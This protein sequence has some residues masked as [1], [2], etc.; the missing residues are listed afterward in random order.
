MK[1]FTVPIA[2]EQPA[3]KKS[4]AARHIAVCGIQVL[5][6]CVEEAA[7]VAQPRVVQAMSG[8]AHHEWTPA[9]T[10]TAA[11]IALESAQARC[12]TAFIS[13]VSSAALGTVPQDDAVNA[14]RELDG[15]DPRRCTKIARDMSEG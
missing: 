7:K 10:G 15:V 4:A 8:L 6:G 9:I 5:T 2:R 3:A 13:E 12:A 1:D 11:A 14:Q